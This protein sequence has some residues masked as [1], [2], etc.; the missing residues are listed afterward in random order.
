MIHDK[1]AILKLLTSFWEIHDIP[2]L[3]EN[4]SLVQVSVTQNT[5]FSR[6]YISVYFFLSHKTRFL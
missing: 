1:D 4:I 2:M 5:L 3:A 6:K